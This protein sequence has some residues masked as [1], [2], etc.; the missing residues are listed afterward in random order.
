MEPAA[1]NFSSLFNQV[2]FDSITWGT[3]FSVGASILKLISGGKITGKIAA[4]L[5]SIAGVG[6]FTIIG[7]NGD[8]TWP[9]I[10]QAIVSGNGAVWGA[11]GFYLHLSKYLE[12]PLRLKLFG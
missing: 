5:I 9:A 11:K 3:V 7:F 8:W 1:I 6:Y 2:L 10:V 12:K 4:G